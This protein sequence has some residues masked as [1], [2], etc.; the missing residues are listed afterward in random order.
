MAGGPDA[1][2][3][4]FALLDLDPEAPWDDLLFEAAVA[5]KQRE[6]SR[7]TTHPT[8][9]GLEA[10][11]NLRRL[12]EIR[13][14]LRDS[15]HR[16]AAIEAAMAGRRA[17]R[18]A[19]LAD[20]ER[21]IQL[22][23]INGFAYEQQVGDLV[24]RFNPPFT[25]A[26]IRHRITVEVRSSEQ[27]EPAQARKIQELLGQLGQRDLYEFLEL[28]SNATLTDLRRRAGEIYD[29]V[30]RYA[31]KTP[32]ISAR[33]ELAGYCLDLFKD[34][35]TRARYDATRRE[36][37]FGPLLEQVDLAASGSRAITAAQFELLLIEAQ[38][39]G[40]ERAEAARRIQA[41]A[42]ER[43]WAIESPSAATPRTTPARPSPTAPT[44][45]SAPTPAAPARA[46][47]PHAPRAVLRRS[48]PV[49]ARLSL[50]LVAVTGLIWLAASLLWKLAPSPMP[51][52]LPTEDE[53][54][55]TPEAISPDGQVVASLSGSAPN[56]ARLWRVSDGT[57]LAALV[58]QP[59]EQRI[60]SVAFSP[61]GQTVATTS[62][63]GGR[64]RLWR[65]AD[66]SDVGVLQGPLGYGPLACD[67]T[68]QVG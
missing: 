19:K 48:G 51:D 16:A 61:D 6:W 36:L 29:D 32:K 22:I 65:V 8:I 38:R 66:G 15:A 12:S 20:L 5:A 17:T 64:T 52:P 18:Q 34:G 39:L 41:R 9:K 40:L 25:E 11:E 56:T 37:A 21:A 63:S 68:L 55:W 13:R 23:S 10:Q 59:N 30:Q 26:E 67:L 53:A 58:G 31:T 45:S 49:L 4:Y 24:A 62:S 7:L 28:P 47:S 43:G 14:A 33:A 27:L 50:G 1:R 35:P 42:T 46:A 2:P 60:T 44:P 57:P 3:D 54:P